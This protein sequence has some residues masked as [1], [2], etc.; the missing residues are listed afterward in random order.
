MFQFT[1]TKAASED[2]AWVHIKD[3]GRPAHWPGAD[4]K[5]D[6]ARPVR[7]KVLGEHSETYKARS[8]KRAAKLLKDRGG[9]LNIEKMSVVE[10]ETLIE[11]GEDA[12]AQDWADRTVTWENMPGSDG[13]PLD[14]SRENAVAIY[15][16]YPKIVAQ[17]AHD[18]GDIDDFLA[19]TSQG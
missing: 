18:A 10:I 7:V 5:P 3:K 8:R 19:L 16:A 9:S 2:G 15:T 6:P 12:T 17:L 4:G 1:D 11:Q 14:F 13:Q